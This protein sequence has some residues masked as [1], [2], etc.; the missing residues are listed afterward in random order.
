M[1]KRVWGILGLTA[2]LVS[3]GGPNPNPDPNPNPPTGTGYTF[4]PDPALAPSTPSLPLP[5]GSGT[6]PVAA[7]K[8][9]GDAPASELVLNEVLLSTNDETQVQALLQKYGGSIVQKVEPPSNLKG[10]DTFYDIKL[11]L[12]KVTAGNIAAD[13]AKDKGSGSGGTY[14]VSNP[15]VLKLMRVL[16]DERQLGLEPNYVAQASGTFFDGSS[17]NNNE[18]ALSWHDFQDGGALDIGIQSAWL[19]LEQS[20][21]LKNRVRVAIIDRGINWPAAPDFPNIVTNDARLPRSNQ[22]ET[23]KPWHGTMVALALAGQADNGI[24]AA[25]PGAPVVDTILMEQNTI[26]EIIEGLKAGMNNGARIFNMSFGGWDD[27]G[28]SG[29][30]GGVKT[31]EKWTNS[32]WNAGYLLF[33][34]AGNEGLDVDRM[35]G[36]SETSWKWPCENDGVICVGGLEWQKTTRASGSNYGSGHGSTVDIWAPFTVRVG[37]YATGQS[38]YSTV[39]GTSFSSPFTAGVAALIWAAN[40]AMSN[41]QVYDLMLKYAHK[42]TNLPRVNAAGPVKEALAMA[43]VNAPPRIKIVSPGSGY[44][45]SQGSLNFPTVLTASTWDVED[46]CCTVTWSSDLDGPMGTGKTLNYVFAGKTVGTRTVTA[47]ATDKGGKTASASIKVQVI[48]TP[49]TIQIVTPPTGSTWTR[50]LNVNLQA[51]PNDDL[52][53]D[54]NGCTWTSSRAGEGPWT[55]CQ[56][57]VAFTTS[58]TRTLSVKYVD[59]QGASSNTATTLI[60]VNDPPPSGPPIVSMSVFNRTDPYQPNAIINWSIVDP[61]G[62]GMSDLPKY[63]RKWELTLDGVTKSI[64]PVSFGGRAGQQLI[65]PKDAFTIPDCLGNSGE[66]KTVTVTLSVTDPENLTTKTNVNYDLKFMPCIH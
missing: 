56:A 60:T 27:N 46:G 59:G 4:T 21:Q 45:V 66:T 35:K 44:K 47:T 55:G 30:N 50:G 39:S 34:S 23:D 28:W 8:G 15:E 63:T 17:E 37:A 18:D 9:D 2:W 48:N 62:P 64:S 7:I 20:G 42:E 43:G 61:G 5:D 49:P 16:Y 53:I 29:Y 40:P 41:A 1:R 22:K 33:A 31:L 65:V 51:A 3:C 12:S 6:R 19:A 24:G 54:P 14:K 13:W 58:G 26:G 10:L 52:G 11:D 36:S 25:G 57:S 38:G 32:M